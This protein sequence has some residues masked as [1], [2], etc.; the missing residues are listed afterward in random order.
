LALAE[1]TLT[2][3]P[4]WPLTT[5]IKP[6]APIVMSGW[7]PSPVVGPLLMIAVGATLPFAPGAKIT[8]LFGLNIGLFVT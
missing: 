8:M 6:P 7:T 4:H 5:Y 2:A 3:V 1:K